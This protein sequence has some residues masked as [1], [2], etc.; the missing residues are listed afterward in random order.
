MVVMNQQTTAVRTEPDRAPSL[1]LSILVSG[2]SDNTLVTNLVLWAGAALTVVT[3]VIHFHLWSDGYKTIP[4]IGPLFLLQ[5]IVG[6]VLALGVA[7]LRRFWT[8]VIAF[9]F[10]AS[11]IGGFLLSVTIGLF[12]FKDSWSAP[13]AGGAF[14][15]EIAALVLLA[16]G[17]CLCALRSVPGRRTGPPA[18][19]PSG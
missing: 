16:V 12:G 9:G 1:L 19:S 4:T 10:V 5:A 7:A 6:V 3:A 11:T 17:G 2:G 18:G 13:W 8:A 15:V 14:V